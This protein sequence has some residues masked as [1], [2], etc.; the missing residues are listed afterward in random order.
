MCERTIAEYEEERSSTKEE[1]ERQHQLLDAVFKN[2]EV[3]LH[4][5]DVQQSPRVN[6][7]EAETQHP[8]IKEEE[9]DLWIT[10]EGEC[11]REQEEAESSELHRSP[12][13]FLSHFL[14]RWP[15]TVKDNR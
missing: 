12:K 8:H 10:Q 7:E 13:A 3:V 5:T 9:E 4:R 15:L 14:L 2:D 1:K 6:E 11:L